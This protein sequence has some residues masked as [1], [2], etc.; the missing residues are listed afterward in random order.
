MTFH[1]CIEFVVVFVLFLIICNGIQLAEQSTQGS[2]T[3][4]DFLKK[5]GD[6]QK[7]RRKVSTD[8]KK[9]TVRFQFKDFSRFAREKFPS[10]CMEEQQLVFVCFSM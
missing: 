3:M 2:L 1:Y 9:L 10:C 7:K 8:K 5:L 4:A 6:G